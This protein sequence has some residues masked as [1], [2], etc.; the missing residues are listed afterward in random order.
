MLVRSDIQWYAVICCDMLF[1][2]VYLKSVG[3]PRVCDDARILQWKCTLKLIRNLPLNSCRCV[4]RWCRILATRNEIISTVEGGGELWSRNCILVALTSLGSL[5]SHLSICPTKSMKYLE[6]C[7]IRFREI[8]RSEILRT[9]VENHLFPFRFLPF[10][11]QLMT[12]LA[13]NV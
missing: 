5:S 7:R 4:S 2:W 1:I 6:N 11:A 12:F 9:S 10:R 8:W 13:K 3:C